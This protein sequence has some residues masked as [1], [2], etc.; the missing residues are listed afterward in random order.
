[1][2]PAAVSG[3]QLLSRRDALL[4]LPEI[5]GPVGCDGMPAIGIWLA[6][7]EPRISAAVFFGGVS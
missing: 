4:S 3:Q 6:M 1:V 7:V 5:G 2:P